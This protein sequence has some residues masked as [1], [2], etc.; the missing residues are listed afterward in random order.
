MKSVLSALPE[1]ELFGQNSVSPPKW[2]TGDLFTSELFCDLLS[3]IFEKFSVWYFFTLGG[4][5]GAEL[6]LSG[7][8]FE[9]VLAL[10][11]G[12]FFDFAVNSDLSLEGHPV[13]EQFSPG[14]VI[15]EFG[16]IALIVGVE[17]EPLL[18]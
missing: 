14:V 8:G 17:D 1:F 3:F 6:A 5:P 10:F 2:R 4:G 16:F 13:E 15:E 11:S 12:D 7:T 9:V 18:L